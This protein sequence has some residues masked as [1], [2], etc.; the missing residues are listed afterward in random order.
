MCKD[1]SEMGT[2]SVYWAH[3]CI[4][5]LNTETEFSLRNVAFCIQGGIID[6]AQLFKYA[7]S[8]HKETASLK[9]VV[10]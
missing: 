1:T 4:F 6:S 7:L 2:S 10:R 5:H 8:E 3:L 9:R